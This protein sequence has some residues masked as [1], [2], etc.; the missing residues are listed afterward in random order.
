[1]TEDRRARNFLDSPFFS[2]RPR[3]A[4]PRLHDLRAHIAAALGTTDPTRIVAAFMA[5]VGTYESAEEY[6][7]RRITAL[8]PPGFGWVVHCCDPREL[9]QRYETEVTEIWTIEAQG[10][11]V[12]VFEASRVA[13]FLI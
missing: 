4:E 5:Y 11:A 8:L 7:A 3:C 9:R 2:L 1:M 10:G 13:N 6:V 12:L